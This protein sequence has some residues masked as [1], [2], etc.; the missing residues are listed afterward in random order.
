[1]YG[2]VFL[3]E[4]QVKAQ[5]PFKRSVI[6]NYINQVGQGMKA[7]KYRGGQARKV[8]LSSKKVFDAYFKP[9]T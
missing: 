3:V 4:G 7:K 1:M 8:A 5:Q 6:I 9:L 2:E